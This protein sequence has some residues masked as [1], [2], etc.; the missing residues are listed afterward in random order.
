MPPNVQRKERI[1][2]LQLQ[3]PLCQYFELVLWLHYLQHSRTLFQ[4]SYRRC[5]IHHD[6][7]LMRL[8]RHQL[9]I[10]EIVLEKSLVP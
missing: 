3:Q 10:Q 7:P 5:E 4:V 9:I 1:L 2:P 8:C 6:P